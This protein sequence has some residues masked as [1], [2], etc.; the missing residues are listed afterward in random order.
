LIDSPSQATFWRDLNAATRA[1]FFQS[2]CGSSFPDVS[3]WRAWSSGLNAADRLRFCLHSLSI[4]KRFVPEEQRC[5]A[6]EAWKAHVRLVKIATSHAIDHSQLGRLRDLVFTTSRWM[7]HLYGADMATP[8]THWT[9]HLVDYIKWYSVPRGY[10]T[11]PQ[12]SILS[13]VKKATRKVTNHCSVAYS[14][15]RLFILERLLAQVL[16]P[17][18]DIPK[19]WVLLLA[20]RAEVSLLISFVCRFGVKGGQDA[21]LGDLAA[22]LDL[23]EE[24]PCRMNATLIVNYQQYSVDTFCRVGTSYYRIKLLVSVNAGYY[25]V[26]EEYTNAGFED[27]TGLRVIRPSGTLKVIDLAGAAGRVYCV[28]STGGSVVVNFEDV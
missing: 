8:N 23:P 21:S 6:W 5:T 17:T 14:C 20:G 19:R 2:A 4:L 27:L 1:Y 10:W 16:Q 12:E 11:F 7:I 26:A 22:S 25:A 24:T 15:A 18:E 13:L 3:S 28:S 9:L